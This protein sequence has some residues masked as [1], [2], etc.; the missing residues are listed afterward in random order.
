[1]SATTT[2][3]PVSSSTR[4][5]SVMIV[6][7]QPIVRTGLCNLLSIGNDFHVVGEAAGLAEAMNL[8]HQGPADLIVT[9]ISLNDGSGLELT[10]ELTALN[11]DVRVL[12][13]SAHDDALYSERALRA[14]ARG[15]INK[16]ESTYSILAAMRRIIR[17]QIYLSEE[18][19]ERML[20]RTVGR[21]EHL[22]ISPI[23]TL[24]DRELQVFELI[25]HG[26]TTRKVASQLYL[27]PKTIETY[28]ENIKLKLHLQ[29]SM[30]LTQQ[31]VRWV[32]ENA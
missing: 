30:E 14:G 4:T 12:V 19:T 1:M 3:N 28:R 10:Q 22:D 29:N 6:D 24:S 18:M 13:C 2:T 15:Y 25:G 26:N 11:H 9:E 5:A 27:S 16:R 21:D 7:N 32:L 17:G 8:Y 23:D 31:A 20:C